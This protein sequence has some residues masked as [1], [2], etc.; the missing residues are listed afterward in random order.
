MNLPLP[1]SALVPKRRDIG[2]DKM[3]F[4]GQKIISLDKNKNPRLPK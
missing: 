4:H 1:K 3:N 2:S